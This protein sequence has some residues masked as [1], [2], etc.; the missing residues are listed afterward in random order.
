MASESQGMLA[1]KN[2]LIMGVANRWSIA[3]AIGEAMKAQGATL[4]LSYLD[5]RMKK[6]CDVLLADQPGGKMYPCD[7]SKDEDIDALAESIKQD[8]GRLDGYIHSVGFAPGDALKNRFVETSRDSWRI[9]LDVSAYSLVA[10]SA[11][12]APLMTDG[13]SIQTLTYLGSERVFP[14]YKVMGVA[15]A[16]LEASVRYLAWDLGE[17]GIRVNAISAGPIKSAAAR[18]IPGFADMYGAMLERAP[19]KDEFGAAQVAS[20]AVFLA[21][22]YSSA[23]TGEVIFAD[24]GYHAMG[25]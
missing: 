16:A 12:M 13:G 23:I 8:F 24:N 14:A 4:I 21:S 6:D 2:I 11:R 10:V 25:M 15:K 9:A 1:G 3:Y 18:G 22:D 19:L 5:E 7:V 20:V 17:Q